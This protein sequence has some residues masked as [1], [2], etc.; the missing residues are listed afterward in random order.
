[1]ATGSLRRN[2]TILAMSVLLG[3]GTLANTACTTPEPAAEP[4]PAAENV[5]LYVGPETV[6]CLGVGPQTCLQVRYAPD[7]D[8]EL[9]YSSI[10]G[11]EYAPGYEYELLVQKTPMAN[12]PADGSAIAWQLVD[13]VVQTPVTPEP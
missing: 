4:T 5:T 1:M 3:G 11:F 13:V 2:A 8:Y 12:P 6:D 9:F 10:D 7:D